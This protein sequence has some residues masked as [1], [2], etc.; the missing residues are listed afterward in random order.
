M[1]LMIAL[2]LHWVIISIFTTLGIWLWNVDKNLFCFNFR[3]L[4]SYFFLIWSFDQLVGG[5][6]L[7]W[8]S[9]VEQKIT[10]STALSV[11]M[12]REVFNKET[13]DNLYPSFF[14]VLFLSRCLCMFMNALFLSLGFAMWNPSCPLKTLS[15]KRFISVLFF[16][17]VF[18]NLMSQISTFLYR[19][20]N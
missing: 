19:S 16:I 6:F 13:F 7:G 3:R 2:H 20:T 4:F 8:F 10:I 14:G 1:N 5:F 9:A 18:C 12:N 11:F 17:M 15:L